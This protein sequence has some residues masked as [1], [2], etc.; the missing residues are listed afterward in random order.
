MT[1]EC[2]SVAGNFDG[3]AYV[4]MQCGAHHPMEHIQVFTRSH[5]M[6]PLGDC[7]HR[8]ATAAA[9]V[10]E[11]VAK[12]KNTNKKLFLASNYHTFSLAN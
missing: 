2:T 11:F 9:M 7:L 8:I 5:W 6:L 1:N 12:Y 4:A 10:D 3:H